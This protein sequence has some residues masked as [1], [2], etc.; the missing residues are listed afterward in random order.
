MNE[1]LYINTYKDLAH[2][3]WCVTDACGDAY[4]SIFGMYVADVCPDEARQF[5]LTREI[6]NSALRTQEGE[7]QVIDAHLEGTA[8]T[9]AQGETLAGV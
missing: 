5:L 2:L 9:L 4:A 7:A 1:T 6:L 8:E 3:V